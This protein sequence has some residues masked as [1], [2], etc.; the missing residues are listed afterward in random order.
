MKE[1]ALDGIIDKVLHGEPFQASS[2]WDRASILIRDLILEHPFSDGNKRVAFLALTEFLYKNGYEWSSNNEGLINFTL[3][4][5]S[6]KLIELKPI[7]KWINLNTRQIS[8]INS[9]V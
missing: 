7:S 3:D 9:N 1:Y 5:A 4:I 8:N 2:F 6:G